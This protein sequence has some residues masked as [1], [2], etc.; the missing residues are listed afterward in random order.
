LSKRSF[1]LS[2]RRRKS[3]WDS[4]STAVLLDMLA[5]AGKAW[6][7]RK[8]QVISR[9]LIPEPVLLPTEFLTFLT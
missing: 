8:S 7:Q 9:T 6:K 2:S 5:V 4:N 1:N 3:F